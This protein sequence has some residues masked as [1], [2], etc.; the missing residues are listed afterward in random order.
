[1]SCLAKAH[2]FPSLVQ[3]N[4]GFY[5]EVYKHIVNNVQST[6]GLQNI[7]LPNIYDIYTANKTFKNGNFYKEKNVALY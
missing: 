4:N 3:I 1:M 5:A 7:V 6:A 2:G